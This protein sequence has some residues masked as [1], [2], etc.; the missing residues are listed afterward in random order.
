[1]AEEIDRLLVRI[2]ANA[3]RFEAQMRQVNRALYGSS[4]QV[5]RTQREFEASTAA[6]ASGF[7]TVSFAAQAAFGAVV[8]YSVRA[9]SEAAE[10]RNA[11]EVA[12]GSG[13]D[14]AR[15]FARTLADEVG[16]SATQVE[17]GMTRLR[18]VL[19]GL[20]IAAEQADQVVF[21][22]TERG[23]DI[24]SLFNV[25]D[26]EAFRAII[27]GISGETEPMKRFGVVINEAAVQAELLRLGFEGNVQEASEAAKAIARA[28]IILERTAVANGDAARTADSAANQFRRA[29][30]EFYEAAVVLGNQLLPAVT[31]VTRAVSDTIEAFTEL[32]SGVRIAGLA[33]LGLIAAGGPIAGVISGLARIVT[34][35]GRARAA[36]AGITGASAAAGAAGAG[37]A[38]AGAGVGAS[39]AAAVGLPLLTSTAS[40]DRAQTERILGQSQ[41]E[42]VAW[43]NR[44]EARIRAISDVSR[45]SARQAQLDAILAQRAS[46]TAAL[47]SAAA[48]EVIQ[49]AQTEAAALEGLD[50]FTLDGIE[51]GGGRGGSGGGGSQGD[52]ADELG[53]RQA[54]FELE[55][56]IAVARAQNNEEEIQRLEE[57]LD[58]IRLT[59]EARELG[60]ADAEDVAARQVEAIREAREAE[61]ALAVAAEERAKRDAESARQ[62][63]QVAFWAEQQ[64]QHDMELAGLMG[65]D[66][67]L[68]TLRRE[69][70]IRRRIVAY[71]REGGM[72][73][74]EARARAT[75]EV[76][77]L[78]DAERQ[79]EMRETF[80]NTFTEGIRAA[81]NGDVGS[82]FEKLADR[83]TQRILDSL[84]DD[85]WNLINRSGGQGGGGGLG[86][87]ISAAMSVFSGGGFGGG[88]PGSGVGGGAPL[89]SLLEGAA[90]GMTKG[91]GPQ[92][93]IVQVD[94]SQYFDV[95]VRKQ[96]APLAVQAAQ[97]GAQQ[98]QAATMKAIRSTQRNALGLT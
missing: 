10:I 32:P 4:A 1:M 91:A 49:G 57:Q 8:L 83:F 29:R 40:G 86:G 66:T 68:D 48:G 76:D 74:A 11:F 87:F 47:E 67:R 58:L 75:A 72:L 69:E 23:I 5:R 14:S 17:Q 60:Y 96:A 54:L 45:R 78:I 93:I 64:L 2:E 90:G 19:D 36:L 6:M 44:E 33:L 21:A 50:R 94:K 46:R 51:T 30:G 34:W 85:L 16:R 81:I 13:T 70:E 98:G 59:N 56:Q 42:F 20:G 80:R 28:N 61:E 22:L 41:S 52:D 84:A 53:R 55:N 62:R 65:D 27:S 77:Q 3:Q 25:E 18:L 92:M 88:V 15:E 39:V 82:F 63:E 31:D 37:G 24:G 12:F 73:E 79:G 71:M 35:A 95:E 7:R 9:A 89:G 43:V 38:A 97:Y 26:A